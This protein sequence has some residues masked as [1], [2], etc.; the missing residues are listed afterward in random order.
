LGFLDGLGFGHRGDMVHVG[1][2]L[3]KGGAATGGY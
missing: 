2:L 1:L 3:A